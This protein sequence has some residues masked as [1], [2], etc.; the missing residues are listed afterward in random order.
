MPAIESNSPGVATTSRAKEQQAQRREARLARYG[1]VMRH[2][3]SGMAIRAIARLTAL[4]WRTVRHWINA[5][6][7]AE[8]AQR[9]PA[10]SKLDPYRAYLAHRWREG[11]QNAARLYWEIVSQGFNGGGGIVRQ[12]LQP[13]RQAC[14]IT[15]QLRTAVL[16]AVPCTRRVGCW[17]MGRGTASLT[18]DNKRHV[19]RFV[20]RLGERNPQIATI[21]RLSLDS[22]T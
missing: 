2:H 10:A 17:L 9:P 22:L 3:Q 4:D 20:Q 1:T 11:C 19:Q 12:A 14:A 18:N 5:G 7:F 6:G 15:Q 8:R 21:R 13:W 16:R